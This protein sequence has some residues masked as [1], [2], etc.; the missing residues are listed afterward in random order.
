VFSN[1]TGNGFLEIADR[2]AQVV[3]LLD[4]LDAG[5]FNLAHTFARQ[6]VQAANLLQGFPLVAL[7]AETAGK[8]VFFAL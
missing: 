6:L 2:F 5:R 3:E 7:Q 8:D 4:F 1:Q